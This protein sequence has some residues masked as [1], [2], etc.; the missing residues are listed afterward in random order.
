M[1]D[2][3]ELGV[4]E[5]HNPGP[6]VVRRGGVGTCISCPEVKTHLLDLLFY[7]LSTRP[8]FHFMVSLEY[9]PL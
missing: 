4:R 7:G 1:D 2:S 5:G 3:R 8:M 6:G 9:L